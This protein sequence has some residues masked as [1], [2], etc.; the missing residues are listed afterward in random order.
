MF[1]FCKFD[2]GKLED[3]LKDVAD[4][5]APPTAPLPPPE[6]E[7]IDPDELELDPSQCIG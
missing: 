1:I 7:D 6:E 4:N 5:E 2:E 3:L